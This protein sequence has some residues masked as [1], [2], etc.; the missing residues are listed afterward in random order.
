MV[1]VPEEFG[2]MAEKHISSSVNHWGQSLLPVIDRF[3]FMRR[4][5]S[6]ATTGDDKSEFNPP[7]QSAF[8]TFTT[9]CGSRLDSARLRAMYAR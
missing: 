3:F 8:R 6:D 2:S 7:S 5:I 1:L 4:F 9:A